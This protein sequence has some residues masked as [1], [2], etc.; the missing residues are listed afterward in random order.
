MKQ[1][2]SWRPCRDY[3]RLNLVT[4]PDR[5]PLP[6]MQDFAARL[7]NCTFFSKIDLRK[8]YHQIAVAAQDVPKTAIITP[9][10]L[11]EYTRMPFGL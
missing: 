5:Y 7:D 3:R 8:G 10:R 4:V 9:F 6:N 11:F 2:G 1:D